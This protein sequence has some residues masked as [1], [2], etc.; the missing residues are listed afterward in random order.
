MYVLFCS[1]CV[2]NAASCGVVLVE[3]AESGAGVWL[4][5]VF[6]CGLNPQVFQVFVGSVGWIVPAALR[7][8]PL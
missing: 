4:G 2:H 3:F 1:A 6:V 5:I 8:V 7:F